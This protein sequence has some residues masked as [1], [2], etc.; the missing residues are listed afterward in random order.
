MAGDAS[1]LRSSSTTS[2]FSEVARL[3][4]VHF[5]R[6][7]PSWGRS[8]SSAGVFTSWLV[9]TATQIASAAPARAT[10]E[11]SGASARTHQA[12]IIAQRASPSTSRR[13]GPS[14]PPPKCTARP[15]AIVPTAS[16]TN[17]C[18]SAEQPIH[19]LHTRHSPENCGFI[20]TLGLVMIRSPSV[21]AQEPSATGAR[22]APAPHPLRSTRSSR[23][24][25]WQR[26]AMQ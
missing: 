12:I 14:D 16:A 19:Q 1:A 18:A 5:A 22:Q 17:F 11:R 3:V 20:V 4:R 24:R 25:R 10:G 9:S 7:W 23:A 13:V 8:V 21:Q 2:S 6:I 26:A 15:I